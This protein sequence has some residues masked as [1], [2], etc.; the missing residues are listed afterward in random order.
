MSAIGT[1][2]RVTPPR[3]FILDRVSHDTPETGNPLI[4][5]VTRAWEMLVRQVDE[6]FGW[7]PQPA[8]GRV[9]AAAMADGELC[10]ALSAVASRLIDA[11]GPAAR[12]R[13]SIPGD[14]RWRF[15]VPFTTAEHVR[16][17]FGEA[18]DAFGVA[19]TALGDRAS[20]AALA[21]V[22]CLAENLVRTRWLVEPSDAGQRR[23]RGYALTAEAIAWFRATSRRAEDAGGADQAGL[24]REIADRA[25][26]ME[27]R[28]DELIRDDG[29]QA[30]GVP[31]RLTLLQDYLPGAGLA[32]FALFSAAGSRPAGTPSALFYAEPGTPNALYSFQRRYL[33]RAYW[34][35][36]AV[37]F[38]ADLCDA[39]GPVLGSED[40]AEIIGAADARF[41]PLAQEADRRYRERLHGGMHPG[42]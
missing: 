26:T 30:V 7:S 11:I 17:M 36:H 32:P 8:P 28:L 39:A 13:L 16:A 19:V 18:S 3:P 42:L 38:Y 21:A 41:R 24:A 20:S 29:L 14:P 31:K 23:E 25:G 34:L 22:A 5:G 4:D 27:S 35:G 1:M 15:N 9:P 2:L 37:T 12:V 10:S 33:T 6:I 40:W